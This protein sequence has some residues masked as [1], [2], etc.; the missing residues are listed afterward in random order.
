MKDHQAD[1]PASHHSDDTGGHQKKSKEISLTDDPESP[2]S[3]AKVVEINQR[4]IALLFSYN[5]QALNEEHF[6]RAHEANVRYMQVF[7]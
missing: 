2:E 4:T 5:F 6:R 7:I 1:R 3:I